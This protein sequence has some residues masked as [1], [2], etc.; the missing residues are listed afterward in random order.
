MMSNYKRIDTY[1]GPF[2]R[3]RLV[4]DMYTYVTFSAELGF[5]P[6]KGVR[7]EIDR[8]LGMVR[9]RQGDSLTLGAPLLSN[10]ANYIRCD[11]VQD[12]LPDRERVEMKLA[13]D[14]WW[15][16]YYLPPI[17]LPP[18]AIDCELPQIQAVGGKLYVSNKIAIP[19]DGLMIKLDASRRRV[20]ITIHGAS[21]I[22]KK[23]QGR[24][25]G[26]TPQVQALLGNQVISMQRFGSQWLGTFGEEVGA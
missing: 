1:M 25:I 10:K 21:K 19:G 12:I 18:I 20:L 6:D 26:I 16:G 3:A 17:E 9:V 7:M 22:K 15:Y 13:E 11:N 24:G 14:G 4:Q 2:I 8:D 5:T 23:T